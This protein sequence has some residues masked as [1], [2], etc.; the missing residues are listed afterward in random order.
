M[1]VNAPCGPIAGITRAADTAYLGIP[2]ARA[3]YPT[4]AFDLPQPREPF[5]TCFKATGY[6]PSPAHPHVGQDLFPDPVIA[7]ED[8]LNLNV[9]A[10]TR[11]DG[12]FP[13][14]VW[15]Y[16]GGFFTGSNAS[17]W[18]DGASFARDG[19]VFVVPNYR[20]A[21]EGFMILDDGVA[22]RALLDITA[23]LT[24][25]RDNI[26]AFGGDP[27]NVTL[28]GQSAGAT[29]A[30]ALTGVPAARGLFRRLAVMSAGTPLLTPLDRMKQLSAD[31]ADR[32]GIPP[33][34]QALSATP[35]A[36]RMALEQEW[37]P[38]EVRAPAESA[39][40]R[41]RRAGR[42]ALRWQPTLDG[43]V[44]TTAPEE[45]LAE[46]G[47]L[48]ALLIGTTTQ[49]WNFLLGD[50][51]TAPSTD[52]C[53]HGMANLGRTADDLATYLTELRSD[54]P[55]H[56]LAQ[57][58]TDRTFRCPART[59]ADTAAR[60][61]IPTHTYQF[62]WPAPH[63]GAAHC[64][65]LPFVFDHLDAPQAPQLLGPDAPQHLA[66]RMHTA[67]TRFA[68]GNSPGWS[69]YTADER[70]TMVFDQAP[71][72][73]TDALAKTPNALRYSA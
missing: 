13:V 40:D 52:A 14:V 24:W 12:P 28:A 56:A 37:L 64:A 41:A 55:G 42:D 34:R 66:D 7:G 36:R 53:L 32:L 30:L 3:P 29:A 6:G 47:A 57:A 62:A 8:A 16:G 44:V 9:H 65:D 39:D 49:E 73:C 38:G 59:I 26:A 11:G 25:V 71:Y 51:S 33:T 27:A 61:G 45:A 22:N 60:A 46:P 72:E 1:S 48:D 21:A 15:L 4:R 20:V 58:L 50:L 54:N 67:L 68:H 43:E 69:P 5:T 70:R 18:Y 10:P 31:F 63:F 19:V 17:P 35:T 2:Y 23:A